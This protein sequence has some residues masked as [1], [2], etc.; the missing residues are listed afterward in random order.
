M[1]AQARCLE[2]PAAVSGW[3]TAATVEIGAVEVVT[4]P[5]V[6]A[7]EGRTWNQG[8]YGTFVLY[9]AQSSFGHPI[10]TEVDWGNGTTTGWEQNPSPEVPT[11][12]IA[13][14]SI[15]ARARCHE[16][17]EIV[18]EWSETVIA[19]VADLETIT[20]PVLTGPST[21]IKNSAVYFGV[22]GAVSSAGHD[23]EYHLYAGASPLTTLAPIGDWLPAA[24]LYA[25]WDTAY[26]YYVRVK[27]R[28][29]QHPD[30]ESYESNYV[31]VTIS[32]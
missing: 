19:H 8:D 3:S 29:I 18:S 11:D 17:P 15:R 1:R 32:E 5:N 25:I 24:S 27:A 31:L 26:F 23:L 21:G 20:T 12:D 28:C 14:L 13:E 2:H 9:G 22:S 10:E 7:A 6:S 4:P 16:H 30:V